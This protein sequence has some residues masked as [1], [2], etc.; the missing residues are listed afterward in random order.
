MKTISISK[1]SALNGGVMT[2]CAFVQTLANIN[3]EKWTDEEWDAWE[4]LYYRYC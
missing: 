1:L 3:G 2:E 4:K